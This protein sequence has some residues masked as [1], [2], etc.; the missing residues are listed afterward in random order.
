MPFDDAFSGVHYSVLRV[1][2][3]RLA[4]SGTGVGASDPQLT[5]VMSNEGQ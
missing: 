5:G 3:K 4:C 1:D 2:L